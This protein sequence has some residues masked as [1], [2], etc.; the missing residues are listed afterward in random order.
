MQRRGLFSAGFGCVSCLTAPRRIAA[1]VAF[2][3]ILYPLGRVQT[4]ERQR[5]LV[6]AL[7]RRRQATAL[8]CE[9][10]PDRR[11]IGGSLLGARL[12]V[13][14]A[15]GDS[16]GR[17]WRCG[18]SGPI[19]KAVTARLSCAGSCGSRARRIGKGVRVRS[20]V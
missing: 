19:V 5:G 18:H 1:V 8:Y 7:N 2:N 16:V 4:P 15:G 10:A 17:V 14:V 12:L 3:S 11:V 9:L 20:R 6:S 13:D